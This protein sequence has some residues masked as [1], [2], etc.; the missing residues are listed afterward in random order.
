MGLDVRRF[1]SFGVIK[2]RSLPLLPQATKP[3]TVSGRDFSAVYVVGLYFFRNIA[4]QSRQAM[5]LVSS[6]QR[7]MQAIH[8]LP[9]QLKFLA[10]RI[11]AH[12]EDGCLLLMRLSQKTLRFLHNA[13]EG[14]AVLSQLHFNYAAEASRNLQLFLLEWI[15]LVMNPHRVACL[16]E[17]LP[18]SRHLQIFPHFRHK[19]SRADQRSLIRRYQTLLEQQDCQGPHHSRQS[20]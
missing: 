19:V 20:F 12:I 3:H 18:W 5:L 9:H 1:T 16:H 11:I 8:R 14:R 2:V 6:V 15:G 10:H 17:D 13:C 7:A 4:F